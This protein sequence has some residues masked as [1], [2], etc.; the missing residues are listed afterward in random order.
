MFKY[1]R[2]K[3][4]RR[5]LFLDIR[6]RWLGG[7]YPMDGVNFTMPL[8]SHPSPRRAV[9]RGDYEANERELIAAHLP[10]DLP[11]IE[12][13]GSYG[14]VSHAIRKRL[15]PTSTLVV[16]EANPTMIRTCRANV[17]LGGSPE[18]THV[19]Q[20]A[21]AYGDARVRF[22]VALYA[23]RGSKTA[24]FHE[25]AVVRLMRSIVATPTLKSRAMA[26]M[27]F[28]SLSMALT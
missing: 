28:P 15:A 4:L 2:L 17:A 20:A 8:G 7:T 12:L 26:R 14:I 10:P 27:D 25:S 19:V 13:G 5:R 3:Y 9:L 18:R 1:S 6:D 16:V 22:K 24:T 21:L 11:V 23:R